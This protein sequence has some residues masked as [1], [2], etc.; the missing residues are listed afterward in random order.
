MPM[1]SKG[2][3]WHSINPPF[4]LG[5]GQLLVLNFERGGGGGQKK[6]ECLDELKEFLPEIF[7]WEGL[8][9]FLSTKNFAK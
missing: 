3:R 9:C 2:E 7:A 1:F 6:I 8:L 4:L 5:G